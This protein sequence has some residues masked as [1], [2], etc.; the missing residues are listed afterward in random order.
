M[1]P[2]ELLAERADLFVGRQPRLIV[3]AQAT[4]VFVDDP[5]QVWDRLADLEQLVDLLLIL[6]DG[7]LDFRVVEDESHLGGNRV[8]VHRHRDTTEALHCDHREVQPRPVLA[9]DRQVLA[10]GE[11][12]LMQPGRDLTNLGQHLDPS[13]ALPDAQ[14]LLAD[15]R[16]SRPHLSMEL[17]QTREGVGSDGIRHDALSPE[18]C[19][20]VPRTGT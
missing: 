12:G 13:P 4:R 6:N 7:K 15:S 8:L 18:S 14:I 1:L 2:Q 5:L 11:A 10:T 20:P 16:R 17:D 9:D 19:Y 3:V